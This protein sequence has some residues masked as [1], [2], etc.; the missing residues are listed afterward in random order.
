MLLSLFNYLLSFQLMFGLV[1]LN[2]YI[3]ESIGINQII[4]SFTIVFYIL[5][6]SSKIEFKTPIKLNPIVFFSFAFY[7]I[8]YLFHDLY[9]ENPLYSLI[10]YLIILIGI[11]FL[12]SNLKN[13]NKSGFSIPIAI[14]GTFVV[15]YIFLSILPYAIST[16]FAARPVFEDITSI[17]INGNTLAQISI[18]SILIFLDKIKSLVFKE[19]EY[20][21]LFIKFI[22]IP[23]LFLFVI[24]TQSIS[25]ITFLFLIVITIL[26][27]SLKIKSN[28]SLFKK[29]FIQTIFYASGFILF[30][31]TFNS[32]ILSQLIERLLTGGSLGIRLPLFMQSIDAFLKNPIFGSSYH[33]VEKFITATWLGGNR[34][35]LVSSSNH[36][37]Y[38][39]ILAIY[40]L[41]GFFAMLFLFYSIFFIGFNKRS[42]YE[43]LLIIFFIWMP[44]TSPAY[45]FL[46]I[47][48]I[49]EEN[50]QNN[51]DENYIT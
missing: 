46:P 25:C 33:E 14:S 35:T 7:I 51:R 28:L 30:L 18:I 5:L 39:N 3:P 2:G 43:K 22:I 27:E 31:I 32:N 16:N 38:T 11:R 1:L 44:I 49:L 15:I 45:F 48:L 34:L 13:N 8:Y 50:K 23:L 47:S 17:D 12:I 9:E 36:T 24:F 6:I 26:Y 40:G 37:Y 4:K 41:V 19:K 29:N 20:I 42:N 21:K 10:K